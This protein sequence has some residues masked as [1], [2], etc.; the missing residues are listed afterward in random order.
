MQHI[1]IDLGGVKSQ[2]CVRSQD[3]QI[4][5]E[6]KVETLRLGAMLEREPASRVVLETC[7]EA[8]RIADLAMASGH[9]VRVVPATLV[10]TLG[11]TALAINP[12]AER[13]DR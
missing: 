8:F 12:T 4:L 6:R 7:A 11:G 5:Q 13:R 2:V 3:G 1:A 10:K 9:E